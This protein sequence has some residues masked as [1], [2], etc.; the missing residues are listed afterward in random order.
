MLT[1]VLTVS[2]QLLEKAMNSDIGHE[3]LMLLNRWTEN[4]LCNIMNSL[5][6]DPDRQ[7]DR[8]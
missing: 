6:R 5:T 1:Q 8:K 2:Y 4:R 7:M 3:P